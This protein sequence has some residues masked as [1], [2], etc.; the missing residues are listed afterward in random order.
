MVLC[1]FFPGQ[2]VLILL[3]HRAQINPQ[4]TQGNTPLHF[5]CNN[6]HIES[7][8]ILLIVRLG[9]RGGFP[10]TSFLHSYLFP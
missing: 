5:T 9:L 7:A 1:H 4:D 6:G 8:T 10:I 3:D 2:I